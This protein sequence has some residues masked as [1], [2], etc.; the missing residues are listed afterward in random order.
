MKKMRL[1]LVIP[2]LLTAVSAGAEVPFI[3][4]GMVG[5]DHDV[6]AIL[7]CLET[8]LFKND[9]GLYLKP[10]KEKHFYDF[11]DGE[12]KIAEIEMIEGTSCTSVCASIADGTLDIGLAGIGPIVFMVDKGKGVKCIAPLQSKGNIIVVH[13]S[14]KANNWNEFCDWI[15]AHPKQIHF[16]Y[17]SPAE[18]ANLIVQDALGAEGISFTFS[19]AEAKA[20]VLFVLMKGDKF[21]VPALANHIIDAYAGP[22]PWAQ[23][24]V[25]KGIGKK[26]CNVQDLPPGIWGNHP[27]CAIGASEKLIRDYPEVGS[28]YLE[29]LII[30]SRIAVE[31]PELAAKDAAIWMKTPLEVERDAIP[32][33]GFSLTPDKD[34]KDGTYNWYKVMQKQGRM[35]DKLKD[36]SKQQLER[37]SYDFSLVE[38]A[39][40]D[41]A[42]RKP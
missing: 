3:K 18:V 39:M 31:N 9:Y 15:R 38:N 32:T 10:V 28:K 35:T 41:L 11:Y 36:A 14:V 40:R 37:L 21:A 4:V 8:D 27:C 16:G 26:I 29:L 20:K 24:S 34:F 25:H 22:T 23:V 17:R 6:A 2:L 13:P 5:H 7:P 19:P 1:F 12:K 42:V 33:I 30:G